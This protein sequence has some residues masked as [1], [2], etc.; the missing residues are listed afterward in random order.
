[1]RVYAPNSRETAQVN[2]S[3]VL[4]RPHVKRYL[5]Q[6]QERAM[7]KAD[8]T[9]DHILQKYEAAFSLAERQQKPSEMTAAATAQ[10][11][12]VGLLRDRVETGA[13][14]DFGDVNSISDILELVAKEAGP[15]AA[16]TLAAMFGLNI[17]KSN[18]TKSMEEAILF[19][20]DPASNARN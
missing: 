4:S 9:I 10:A 8:I 20:A 5:H 1:M 7:K 14:G 11:K 2:A 16:M 15:E 19:I 13:V 3:K 6:L 17:P 12:L 18:A